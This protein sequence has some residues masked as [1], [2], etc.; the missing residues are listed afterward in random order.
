MRLINDFVAPAPTSVLIRQIAYGG[1]GRN[2]DI[3][4]NS[5]G[6]RF[7]A[8]NLGDNTSVSNIDPRKIILRSS[9]KFRVELIQ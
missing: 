4:K 9:G 2:I 3:L 8:T 7:S 6:I 5:S 1:G